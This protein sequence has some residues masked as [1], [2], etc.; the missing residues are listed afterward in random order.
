MENK[1]DFSED[2]PLESISFNSSD[3]NYPNQNVNKLA[4][5]NNGEILNKLFVGGLSYS[6]SED[7]F[8]TYF[9]KFG[10]LIDFVIIRDTLTKRSRGF[11]FVTYSNIS[12]VDEVMK[13]RPHFI[14]G[15]KLDLK[16]ISP[17]NVNISF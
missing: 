15:R 16:R 2:V 12:T 7:I 11:G 8:K 3:T 13:K 4:S 1:L 17:K 5:E 6:T 10:P 9:E 14:D